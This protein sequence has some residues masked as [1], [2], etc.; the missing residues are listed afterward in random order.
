MKNGEYAKGQTHKDCWKLKAF[1]D[2]EKSAASGNLNVASGFAFHT[3]L[4]FS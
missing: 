1:R 4:D 3:K 2:K